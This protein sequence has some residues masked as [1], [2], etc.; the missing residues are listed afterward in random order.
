MDKNR[1]LQADKR[2]EHRID[3][4]LKDTFPASDTPSFVGAG[5]SNSPDE[6]IAVKQR[7]RSAEMASE[8]IDRSADSSASSE[9]RKIRKRRLL[10]G[11]EEFRSFRRDRSS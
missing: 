10:K 6:V 7:K 8:A 4:A 3:E 2:R 9:D 1:K 11:P 5:A